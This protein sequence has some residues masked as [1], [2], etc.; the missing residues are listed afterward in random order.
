[1]KH[2]TWLKIAEVVAE[3]SKCISQKVGCVIV[4]NNRVLSTGYNGTPSKQPNCCDVNQHLVNDGRFQDWVSDEAKHEHHE[5]SNIHEIHA[6]MNALL[7]SS[8]TERQGATL[9][10][11][12]QPCYTCSKLIAGSGISRVIYL[13]NYPRTPPEAIKVLEDAG[14]IVNCIYDKGLDK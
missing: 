1:M 12:L 7:Y 13:K 4:K 8:P 14:I 3:E 9:Y 6:E 5:W 2:T 11:T 10:T